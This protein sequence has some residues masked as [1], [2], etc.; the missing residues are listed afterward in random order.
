LHLISYTDDIN[1]IGR[2]EIAIYELYEE[3]KERAK[4]EGRKMNVEIK[5]G[6][7]Q[8]NKEEEKKK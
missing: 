8:E 6:R 1:I 3:L 5:S 7:K 2:T 4:A